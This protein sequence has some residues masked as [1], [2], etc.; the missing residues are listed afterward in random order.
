MIIRRIYKKPCHVL[1]N[2]CNIVII[3]TSRNSRYLHLSRI[4]VLKHGV[5]AESIDELLSVLLLRNILC[6]IPDKRINRTIRVQC[7]HDRRC[8]TDFEYLIIR[9]IQMKISRSM[10]N[11]TDQGIQLIF[12]YFACIY[13]I[14]LTCG[15]DYKI[16]LILRFTVSG[17]QKIVIVRLFSCTPEMHPE[18]R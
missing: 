4:V 11:G 10:R 8:S 7:S 9:D 14:I 1:R 15:S 13:I 2:T 12:I 18:A 6:R 17:N 5:S 16:L 3:I